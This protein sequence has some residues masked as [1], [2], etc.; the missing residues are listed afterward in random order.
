MSICPNQVTATVFESAQRKARVANKDLVVEKG[1][2][3]LKDLLALI[4]PLTGSVDKAYFCK[5]VSSV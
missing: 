5:S 3:S 2:N 1:V 4:N